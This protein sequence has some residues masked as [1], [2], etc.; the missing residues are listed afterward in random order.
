MPNPW[1]DDG[2]QDHQG[3]IQDSLHR[4]DKHCTAD[5]AARLPAPLPAT[6]DGLPATLQSEDQDNRHSRTDD[7]HAEEAR[8]IEEQH[9]DQWVPVDGLFQESRS[10]L[11]A[12]PVVQ[13][14]A[15]WQNKWGVDRK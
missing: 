14:D 2:Y 11:P 3:I 5:P 4:H 7:Q 8:L 13:E 1:L 9:F 6:P 10:A 12:F 15:P